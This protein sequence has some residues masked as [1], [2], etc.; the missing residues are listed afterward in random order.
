M[1]AFAVSAIVLSLSDCTVRSDKLYISCR[2][3]KI[4][5]S[6]SRGEVVLSK[7]RVFF[8]RTR[9]HNN[10]LSTFKRTETP[11]FAIILRFCSFKKAP[12]PVDTTQGGPCQRRLIILVSAWRNFTSPS[13][14]KISEIVLL[15]SLE[16]SASVSASGTSNAVDKIFPTDVFPDPIIPIRTTVLKSNICIIPSFRLTCFEPSMARLL[17]KYQIQIIIQ[18]IPY[19]M[20][21]FLKLFFYVIIIVGIVFIALGYLGP[22]IGFDLTID[23]TL[24]EIPFKLNIN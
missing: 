17:K 20:M 22:I 24:V 15:A 11:N 14:S 21:M 3:S 18:G 19:N 13:R 9:S 23:Q 7:G 16:I 10:S 12:P 4:L 6:V 8:L 2:L 1:T 5:N